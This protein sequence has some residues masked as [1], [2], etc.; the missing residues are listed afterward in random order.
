VCLYQVAS[1]REARRLAE[2]DPAVR[3]GALAVAAM[4]WY[5]PKGVLDFPQ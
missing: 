4:T 3:V 5:T 2:L 1:L